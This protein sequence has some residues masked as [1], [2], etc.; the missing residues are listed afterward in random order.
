MQEITFLDFQ[1][2]SVLSEYIPMIQI[3]KK[4]KYVKQ[5][6]YWT[7]GALRALYHY[8]SHEKMLYLFKKKLSGAELHNSYNFL[9]EISIWSVKISY[10]LV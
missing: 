8:L 1:P 5:W 3:K 10:I 2:L 9:Q 6:L 4:L 7:L